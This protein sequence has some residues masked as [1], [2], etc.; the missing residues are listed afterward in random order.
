MPTVPSAARLGSMLTRRSQKAMAVWCARRI[1]GS[2]CGNA[3]R[4]GVV[5]VRANDEH[6]GNDDDC[7]VHNTCTTMAIRAPGAHTA[8]AGTKTHE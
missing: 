6:A 2:A 1:G 4:D 5:D 7:Q 8:H 3:A